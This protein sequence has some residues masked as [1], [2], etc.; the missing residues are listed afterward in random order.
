MVGTAGFEPAATLYK[1]MTY[2]VFWQN[3]GREVLIGIKKT[4]F[5]DGQSS[6]T[7]HGVGELFLFHY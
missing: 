6:S 4:A 2:R 1:S 3:A 5:D 7:E